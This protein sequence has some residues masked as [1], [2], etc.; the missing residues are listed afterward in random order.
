MTAGE[1]ARAS[2][3]TT[4]A[5]TRLLDRLERIGYAQRVRDSVDRR[6]V[7]VQL[8]PRA[9][10]RA[11]ELYGPLAQAGQRGLERYSAE[12]LIL[13]RDFIRGARAFHEQRTDALVA[14]SRGGRA[15]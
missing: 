1:L 13:L 15:S 4:G 6:R 7:L 10:E 14:R 2:G 12:Q 8:T 11:N 9:R 5:L 3:L